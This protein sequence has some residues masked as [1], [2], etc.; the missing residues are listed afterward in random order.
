M[1]QFVF[2]QDEE[3]R[4]IDKYQRKG[5]LTLRD[6]FAG[7]A[8]QALAAYK[9]ASSGAQQAYMYADAMLKERDAKRKD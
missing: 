5:G 2:P 9:S 8:L 7:C 3:T 1:D 6:Y 4:V